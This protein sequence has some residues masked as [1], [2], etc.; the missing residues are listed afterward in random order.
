MHLLRRWYNNLTGQRD[1]VP[2][3]IAQIAEE[4]DSR[5][6]GEWNEE[7]N[8]P[9]ESPL[10]FPL[11][12]A[13]HMDMTASGS[14]FIDNSEAHNQIILTDPSTNGYLQW[15]NGNNITLRS[16]TDIVVNEIGMEPVTIR[17]DRGQYSVIVLE[18][19]IEIRRRFDDES[20][21]N[22]THDESVGDSVQLGE[23]MLQ[24]WDSEQNSQG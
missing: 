21:D 2:R 24:Q 8:T 11:D 1:Y 5:H 19:R 17:V 15:V 18:D 14:L 16:D 6:I 3:T 20:N 4:W 10:P 7:E 9:E 12:P 23:N 22:G 13:I